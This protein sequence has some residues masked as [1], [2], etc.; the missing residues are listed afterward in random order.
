M[1]LVLI[2]HRTSLMSEEILQYSTHISVLYAV[3]VRG[4]MRQVVWPRYRK[5]CGL[6]FTITQDSENLVKYI[7]GS[8]SSFRNY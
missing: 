1:R 3:F 5:L 8:F 2:M 7:G 6:Q 4:T